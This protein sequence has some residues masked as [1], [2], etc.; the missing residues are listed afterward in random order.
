[1]TIDL[2][3][4]KGLVIDGKDI[5]R[6]TGDVR[7][8]DEFIEGKDHVIG[9]EGLAV[10]PTHVLAQME[11][12]CQA[13][14]TDIPGLGQVGFDFGGKGVGGGQSFKDKVGDQAGGCFFGGDLIKGLGIGCCGENQSSPI[15]TFNIRLAQP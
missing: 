5:P 6:R 13:I 2:L 4:R 9:T 10:V 15:S 14:F 11:R 3:D 7:V 8:V 12:P 1:M